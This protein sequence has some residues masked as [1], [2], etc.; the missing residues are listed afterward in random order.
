MK[1]NSLTTKY[2][3]NISFFLNVIWEYRIKIILIAAVI[4]LI[5]FVYSSRFKESYT[6]SLTLNSSNDPKLQN[7]LFLNEIIL[8]SENVNFEDQKKFGDKIDSENLSKKIM[9][10][11]KDE[12]ADY[13]EFLSILIN[14]KKIPNGILSMAEDKKKEIYEYANFLEITLSNEDDIKPKIILNL[15]WHDI[16]EGINLLE[17]TLKLTL[18]NFEKSIYSELEESLK[19]KK[20]MILNRDAKLIRSLKEQSLIAKELNI[21]EGITNS[22]ISKDNDLKNKRIEFFNG[23]YNRGA[24]AIDKQID[25]IKKREYF[26]F[27]NIEKELNILKES[28]VQWVNYN[29]NLFKVKSSNVRKP[30]L[31]K[32][33]LLG[34]L[35][36]LIYS[37]LANRSWIKATKN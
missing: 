14:Q 1:K 35:I 23:Y 34:L 37:L 29:I 16:N 3:I 9:Y 8:M 18:N 5:G 36:G 31:L 28:K 20:K 2:E 21:F 24:K 6:I 7:I 25:L 4:F 22:E 30:F 12:L 13:D 17:D 26:E 27:A 19:I 15:K 11:I 10:K 32:F 33:M